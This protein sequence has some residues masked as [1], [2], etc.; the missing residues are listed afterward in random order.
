MKSNSFKKQMMTF[1]AVFVAQVWGMSIRKQDWWQQK[2]SEIQEHDK[3]HE[4]SKSNRVQQK[5]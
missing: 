5:T 3:K 4:A 1:C 2:L